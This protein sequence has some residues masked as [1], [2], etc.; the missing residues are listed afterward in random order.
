MAYR[1]QNADGRWN[2][3]TGRATYRTRPDKEAPLWDP[4]SPVIYFWTSDTRGSDR[5]YFISYQGGVNARP[6][7][8]R[9]LYHGYR[10]VRGAG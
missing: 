3:A 1:G 6:R 2:P 7:T 8:T 10:C 9:A 4:F 5:A